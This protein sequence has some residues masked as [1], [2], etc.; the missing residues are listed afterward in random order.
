[1]LIR[2]PLVFRSSK[3]EG[4]FAV[5]KP[6]GITSAQFLGKIQAIFTASEPFAHELNAAKSKAAD[7]FKTNTWSAAKKKKRV[8]SMK[9]KM[10][11]GGTLDPMAS[12]VLIVGIGLGTKKLQKY[13]TEGTKVYDT[14]AL[15]GISTTTGDAE[16]EIITRTQTAHIT[17]DQVTQTVEK[18]VGD[19]TQTPPIFSAL[20]MNGMPLYEYAYKGIP[21]PKNIKSRE[22][23]VSSI[24]VF[25]DD[26][27]STDHEFSTLKSELDA[28]G[29]PKEHGLANNPTL[30]DSPLY[31]SKDY[32]KRAAK[33]GLPTEV[34]KVKLLEEGQEHPD[35]LPLVHFTALVSSGTYIRSLVSDIGR[36][37]ES[38]A[39]MVALTRTRQLEWSLEKNAFDLTD[40]TDR[41]ESVWGPVLRKVFS[42][43]PRVDVKKELKAIEEEG[44]TLSPPKARKRSASEIDTGKFKAR[45]TVPADVAAKILPETASLGKFKARQ[46]GSDNLGKFRARRDDSD[47]SEAEEDDS[48]GNGDAKASKADATDI[49]PSKAKRT[50]SVD[51]AKSKVKKSD[52]FDIAKFKA[53]HTDDSKPKADAEVSSASSADVN[54]TETSDGKSEA[55][56][57]EADKSG[58]AETRPAKVEGTKADAANTEAEKPGP[59]QSEPAKNVG[60]EKNVTIPVGAHESAVK[61]DETE[62]NEVTDGGN[63]STSEGLKEKAS[64]SNAGEAHAAASK[65]AVNGAASAMSEADKT[66]MGKASKTGLGM[67]KPKGSKID[68]SKFKAKPGKGSMI[69]AGKFKA[70]T[71]PVKINAENIAIESIK[72]KLEPGEAEGV[73]AIDAMEPPSKTAEL[74]G[75]PKREFSQVDA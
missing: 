24:N 28:S 25:E 46:D 41:H 65:T 15:F 45:K 31:F 33:E 59:V 70:K 44:M 16:G 30:N 19:L 40:F 66:K 42:Q 43:G 47:E 50:E 57:A 8:S 6:S 11:H 10:G 32:M 48:V 17:K 38:S 53:K 61:K 63:K 12:G 75:V 64:V 9:V 39:Y 69:D 73:N 22:V 36:A 68:A 60:L 26:T 56:S 54:I 18:F 72:I 49:A 4:V 67:F 23:H 58:S 29:K 1:M 7:D 3:M 62:G 37:L 20:K 74:T 27:L 71:S 13:L 51:F 52:S 55:V 34:G 2:P 21:L 5:N 14:K 35:K